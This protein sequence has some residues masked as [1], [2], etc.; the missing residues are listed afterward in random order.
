[1][2]GLEY[3]FGMRVFRYGG[4]ARLS[5]NGEMTLAAANSSGLAKRPVSHASRGSGGAR[6]SRLADGLVD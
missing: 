2:Y 4:I 5:F 6:L 1:M 3:D